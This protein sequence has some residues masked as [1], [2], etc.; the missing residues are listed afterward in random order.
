[1]T[2][3]TLHQTSTCLKPRVYWLPGCTSCLHAKEYLKRNGIE[4]ESRN[5]AAE[6]RAY[7]ELTRFGLKRVPI[8]VVGDKWADGQVLSDV[9]RL[10]GIKQ[11]PRVPLSPAELVRRQ[12]L[13]MSAAQRLLGQVPE[14]KLDT[15]L[16]NRPRTYRQLA[17]HIFQNYDVC[18]ALLQN[19]RPLTMGDLDQGVPARLRTRADLQAFGADIQSRLK[20]WFKQAGTSVDYNARAEVYYGELTKHQFLERTTWHSAQHTRQLAQVVEALG[21]IPDRPLTAKD[22]EGLPMPEH[23]YDDELALT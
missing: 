19:G 2:I 15:L 11:A 14:D 9:A 7:E 16:A 5:V 10:V 8:V 18:L 12:D 23:V 13:V 6:P 17:C 4:F 20:D 22:L 3:A 1:M 21:L